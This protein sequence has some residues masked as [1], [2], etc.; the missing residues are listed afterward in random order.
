MNIVPEKMKLNKFQYTRI[1]ENS[2]YF[3]KAQT[4][5]VPP[6]SS[7]DVEADF[8]SRPIDRLNSSIVQSIAD[9]DSYVQSLEKSVDTSVK[10]STDASDNLLP[11]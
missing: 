9:Y 5:R 7:V 2:E 1:P 8:T 4:L 11:D 10:T 6:R 3:G